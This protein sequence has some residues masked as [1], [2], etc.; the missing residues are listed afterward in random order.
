MKI[1][2][3]KFINLK[4]NNEKKISTENERNVYH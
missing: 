2:E 4:K 1:V 3:V